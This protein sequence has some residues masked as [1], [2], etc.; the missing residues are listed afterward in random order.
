MEGRRNLKETLLDA[1]IDMTAILMVCVVP[2]CIIFAIVLKAGSTYGWALEIAVIAW[3][4]FVRA[5][6]FDGMPSR[7]Y[8][9]KKDEAA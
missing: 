6:F 5:F 3:F 8:R 7:R 9:K 4:I 2:I 1:L